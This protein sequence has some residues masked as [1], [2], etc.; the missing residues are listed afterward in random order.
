MLMRTST[1]FFLAALL[2]LVTSFAAFA[3]A[4]DKVTAPGKVM[5]LGLFHFD[6]PG[7]DAVKYTPIDVM[8]AREQTYLVALSKRIARFAPTKILL[9]YRA[10]KDAVMNERYANF[11][12]G[13]FEL[14]KNEIY[15]IGFRVAKLAGNQRVYGFD[16]DTPAFEDKLWGY[17]ASEPVFEQKLT[18]LI[19][20][21]SARLNQAHRRMSLQQILTMSNAPAEDNRNK[22]F[23]MLLN[24]VGTE[25]GLF[26]GADS[27]ANWW[28]RNLRMYSIVQTHATRGERV[29]VIAGS[30]HAAIQRDL[31]RADSERQAE[32]ILKYF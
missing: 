12:A 24:A 21:E 9:E 10:D 17:L 6:N 3:Q 11:L 19:D 14:P 1:R 18:Q 15:Q 8:Q 31:L 16:V 13:K 23:Y 2:A 25:K 28:Q 20:A 7:F 30:G 29:L 5:F 22:G 4:A 32:D 27:A 26:Y